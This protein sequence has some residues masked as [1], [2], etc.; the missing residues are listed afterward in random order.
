MQEG[1][2]LLIAF[3]IVFWTCPLWMPAIIV[4]LVRR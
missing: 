4:W 1:D 2:P 3:W